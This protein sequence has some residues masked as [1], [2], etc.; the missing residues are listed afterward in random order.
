[1][2]LTLPEPTYL[3]LFMINHNI[4]WLDISVHNSFAMAEVQR[5]GTVSSQLPT[6]TLQSL[7]S[8]APEC[9]IEHRSQQT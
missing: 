6:Q 7:P 5:L 2:K 8:T 1:M 4:V 9:N 3:S